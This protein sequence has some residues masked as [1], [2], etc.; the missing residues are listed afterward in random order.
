M[1]SLSVALERRRL[2]AGSVKAS[3]QFRL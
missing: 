3:R 1:S 2:L